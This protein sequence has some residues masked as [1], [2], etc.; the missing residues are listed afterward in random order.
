VKFVLVSHGQ[1]H[2]AGANGD[3]V[4]LNELGQRQAWA[5]A[6][7]IGAV[8]QRRRAPDAVLTSTQPAAEETAR[9]IVAELGA[10]EP[11]TAI[12]LDA[13]AL[14]LRA[15]DRRHPTFVQE[16]AWAMIESLKERHEQDA[17]IVLVS[18]ESVVRALVCRVLGMPAGD[19]GRF[20][21]AAASIT[22]IEFRG[23]RT[24]IGSLNEVC[25]LESNK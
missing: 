24:L 17:T 1:T 12:E 2:R 13:G 19:M 5:I 9:Q 14:G 10:A 21:L 7:E 6:R 15:A 25:H 8:A 16:R 18:N 20:A 3:V 22:T 23:Q 11:E 4:S